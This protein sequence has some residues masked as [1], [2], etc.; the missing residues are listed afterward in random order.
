MWSETDC[1]I[2][3]QS[4]AVLIH[5]SRPVI[6]AKAGIQLC[7][8]FAGCKLDPRLRGDASGKGTFKSMD[9]VIATNKKSHFTKYRLLT[10]RN[11]Q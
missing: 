5:P 7:H 2:Q 9:T 8:R 11:N 6:P 3:Q 4:F 10:H 1:L